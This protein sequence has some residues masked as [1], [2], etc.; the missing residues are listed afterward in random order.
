MVRVYDPYSEPME[1]CGVVE[2]VVQQHYQEL[3]YNYWMLFLIGGVLIGLLIGFGVGL[4]WSGR[5]S[6]K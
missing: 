6:T 4:W 1:F 3:L 5:S 2:G